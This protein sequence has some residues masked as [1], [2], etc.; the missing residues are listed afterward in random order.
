[1]TKEE[2]IVQELVKKFP[3][4]RDRAKAQRVRRIVAEVPAENFEEVFVYAKDDLK[5]SILCT[6]T[7]LDEGQTLGFIYH[8]AR[9]D[10]ITFSL[11]FSVP[12]DNPVIKSVFKYF[13]NSDIYEREIMDLLGA[14]VEGLT[15][16]NRY[17]L[18]DDWPKDEHPLR[19]DWAPKSAATSTAASRLREGANNA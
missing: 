4:L 10:G 2:N 11:K 13:P 12:K 7:G 14:K 9:I 1:M 5:F 6:I 8:M 3:L 19:K 18:P 15:K 17:P 16:G